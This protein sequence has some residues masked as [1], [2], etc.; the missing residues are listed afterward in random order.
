MKRIL[1]GSIALLLLL[2]LVNAGHKHRGTVPKGTLR[3]MAAFKFKPGVSQ[4]QIDKIL[5]DARATL[6]TIKGVSNVIIGPQTSD[7]TKYTHAMSVDFVNAETKRV[8]AE[9]EQSKRLH[10][11][12]KQYVEDEVILDVL[13]SE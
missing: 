2:T 7:W 8:Y 10:E 5:A 9:S 1:F 3:H 13:M 12:Y 4:E 6:P 11:M